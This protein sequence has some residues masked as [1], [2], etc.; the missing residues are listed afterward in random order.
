[1]DNV[2]KRSLQAEMGDAFMDGPRDSL[3]AEYQD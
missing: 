1:M 3:Q 2:T